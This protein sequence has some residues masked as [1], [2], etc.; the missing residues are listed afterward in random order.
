MPPKSAKGK[1]RKKCKNA[2]PIEFDE[3]FRM[4]LDEHHYIPKLQRQNITAVYR[5]RINLA[6]KAF[7]VAQMSYVG[8]EQQSKMDKVVSYNG[9]SL[10]LSLVPHIVRALGF[11]PSMKQLVRMGWLVLEDQIIPDIL[12]NDVVLRTTW[13]L[14]QEEKLERC[15]MPTQPESID[16]D[17]MANREKLEAL[18]LDLLHDGIFVFDPSK[19]TK[20]FTVIASKEQ[21][22]ACVVERD[23]HMLTEEVLDLL[24][25]ADGDVDDGDSQGASPNQESMCTLLGKT[26]KN[27]EGCEEPPFS[28]E[29]MITFMQYLGNVN[30]SA[31]QEQAD[32][33]PSSGSGGRRVETN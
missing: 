23:S 33:F 14:K 12:A 8:N 19:V 7:T 31:T 6:I 10:S 16:C 28:P 27:E 15:M 21:H 24:M 25:C 5:E 17:L 29:E 1:G 32:T 4:W 26:P 11:N 13:E 20:T 2:L 30:L 3:A 9:R 22:M 18:A